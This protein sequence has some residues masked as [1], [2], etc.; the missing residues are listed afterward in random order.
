MVA[1]VDMVV[2]AAASV[3]AVDVVLLHHAK[4]HRRRAPTAPLSASESPHRRARP[5]CARPL[6]GGAASSGAHAIGGASSSPF[7][8]PHPPPWIKCRRG[9]GHPRP[10]RI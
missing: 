4:P 10:K 3:A 8:P 5:P 2:M 9:R 1:M 6:P 7:R